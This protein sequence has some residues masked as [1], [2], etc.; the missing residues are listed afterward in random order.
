MTMDSYFKRTGAH[1]YTAT[2][3]TSG[4]WNVEEQH[5]SPTLGLATHIIE[6]DRDARRDDDLVI[7]SLKFDILGV[8]PIGPYDFDVRVIRPGRTIELVEAT[9]NHG[10][11]TIVIAR[12]WLMKPG[13]SSSVAGTALSQLPPREHMEPY[14]PQIDWQG[15]YL[16][17]FEGFRTQQ[18]PGRAQVWQRTHADLVDEPYSALARSAG[19]LDVANGLSVREDPTQVAFP[20]V[21]LDIHY[22]RVPNFAHQ[23]GQPSD[24]QGYDVT[25]SFGDG[26][27]GLTHTLVHD[28]HGP[29]AAVTQCLTVRP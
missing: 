23:P 6:S 12:A 21:D 22:F 3:L 29:F 24:W 18:E 9:L 27:L 16:K 13:D 8:V 7:G 14:S 15:D 20:N 2:Q 26:G 1:Q 28:Q 11:R 10:E 19:M 5:I 4:A 17:T 25:V